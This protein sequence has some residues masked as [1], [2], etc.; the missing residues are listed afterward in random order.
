MRLHSRLI[1]WNAY[2]Q[3]YQDTTN[4]C[5]KLTIEIYN[6]DLANPLS[7]SLVHAFNSPFTEEQ[8]VNEQLGGLLHS[9]W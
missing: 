3:F 7:V 4:G 5:S 8:S 9:L 6:A 2:G 1:T